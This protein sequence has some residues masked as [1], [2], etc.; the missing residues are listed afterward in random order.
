MNIIGVSP[1]QGVAFFMVMGSMR[2]EELKL[3]GKIGGWFADFFPLIIVVIFFF[4]LF[5]VYDLFVKCL[6]FE[7]FRFSEKISSET[8]EE[9]REILQRGFI[10]L[11]F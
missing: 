2:L 10:F 7:V 3:I 5:N 6:G 4:T 9:G 8:V 1:Q 11:F